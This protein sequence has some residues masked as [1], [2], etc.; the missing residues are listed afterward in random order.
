MKDRRKVE[1]FSL[2]LLAEI[3][4]KTTEEMVRVLH[5]RTRDISCGGAFFSGVN[6]LPKGTPVRVN[7]TLSA[8]RSKRLMGAQA[9]VEISGIVKRSEPSGMAI[10]FNADYHIM[11]ISAERKHGKGT[12]IKRGLYPERTAV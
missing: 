3:T 10:C 1:R 9:R 6:P 7:L 12:V 2:E 4:V 5:F 8:D 11:P